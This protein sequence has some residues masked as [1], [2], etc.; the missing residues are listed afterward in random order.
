MPRVS[1]VTISGHGSASWARLRYWWSSARHQLSAE[2]VADSSSRRLP[3]IA[4]RR[5][6]SSREW[7][8]GAPGGLWAGSCSSSRTRVAGGGSGTRSAERVP[9]TMR[10]RPRAAASHAARRAEGD[11][12]LS[13]R[14]ASS[15]SAH[16]AAPSRSG[17]ITSAAPVPCSALD[18][19]R[20]SLQ[21]RPQLGQARG[22]GVRPKAPGRWARS[23]A[24]AARAARATRRVDPQG[25]EALLGRPPPDVERGPRQ[26]RRRLHRAL[27][28]PQPRGLPLADRHH[29]PHPRPPL[30]WRAHPLPHPDR[31][32]LGHGVGEGPGQRN[33]EHDVGDHARARWPRGPSQQT[34][35][36][37]RAARRS[38]SWRASFRSS[39]VIRLKLS[40]GLRS[41]KAG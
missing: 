14:A 25:R 23:R 35:A 15:R 33:I 40:P 9:T 22:A 39:H 2:G 21:T 37:Q 38:Y 7:M 41:R 26:D 13:S 1:P 27:D 4:A 31:H 17:A 3:S 32:A 8:R 20:V 18:E 6:S 19:V 36:A 28:G 10:A 34:R 29:H 5:T 30:Q 12:P 11:S 24:R 16:R